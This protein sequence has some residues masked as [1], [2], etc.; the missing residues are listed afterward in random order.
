MVTLLVRTCR[1][2]SRRRRLSRAR[3]LL[4]SSSLAVVLGRLA[5]V[6]RLAR[7]ELLFLVRQRTLLGRSLGCLGLGACGGL[8]LGGSSIGVSVGIG[9]G[10]GVGVVVALVLCRL[11]LVMT[12]V[13]GAAVVGRAAGLV[14]CSLEVSGGLG[15]RGVGGGGSGSI[16]IG[17]G[18]GISISIGV[19]IVV[20]AL[21]LRRLALV[22]TS[23]QRVL[24]ALLGSGSGGLGL[25]T[26]LLGSVVVGGGGGGSSVLVALVLRRLALVVASVQGA[27]LVDAGAG[28]VGC[29]LQI[30]RRLRVGIGIGICICIGVGVALVLCRLALVMA[31]DQLIVANGVHEGLREG[32]LVRIAL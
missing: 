5:L 26:S 17:V 16:A 8:L 13:Q 1:S 30:G 32:M 20:V 27:G 6:V 14:D 12:S 24:L 10:I 28:L 2:L 11:P 7:H 4:S 21:V 31:G 9:I 3:L 25:V 18:V 19:G 22:V 15:V 23:F 29:C